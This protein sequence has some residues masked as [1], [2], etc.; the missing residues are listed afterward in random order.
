MDNDIVYKI[1][2]ED[3]TYLSCII[4]DKHTHFYVH[5]YKYPVYNKF[6]GLEKIAI[7]R[8]IYC[9]SSQYSNLFIDVYTTDKL[10]EVSKVIWI[11][12]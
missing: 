5:K 9:S 12:I 6:S 2:K 7:A 10:I 1:I 3:S 4:E 11:H 8:C